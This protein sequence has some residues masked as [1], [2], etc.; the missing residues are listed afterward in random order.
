MEEP[1]AVRCIVESAPEDILYD[2][3]FHASFAIKVFEVM[4]REGPAMQG[5]ER[6]QQ[7]FRSSVEQLR[8][9]LS[10]KLPA[11]CAGILRRFLAPTSDAQA[12]LIR[13][14]RDLARYKSWTLELPSND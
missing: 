11:E 8:T 7:S 3:T 4:R 5:F 2:L 9:L 12:A 10:S 1:D 6:M 14:M 13:L